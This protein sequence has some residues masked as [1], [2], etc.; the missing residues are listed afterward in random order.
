LLGR[1]GSVDDFRTQQF[2]IT[3]EIGERWEV[4]VDH[5]IL[6]LVE[7]DEPGR[8]D[9][10]SASLGYRLFDTS[11]DR[12]INRLTTGLGLRGYGDFGGE[13]IQNG[14][15]QL[16]RSSPEIGCSKG[17]SIRKN[18]VTDTGCE[19]VPC[20]QVTASWMPHWALTS[21]PGA[22]RSICGSG[23]GTTGAPGMRNQ[24]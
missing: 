3:G 17:K 20:G 11:D 15:H 22:A 23:C 9:Q 4:T 7:A 10:L 2:I 18:G 6:T 19:A 8:T 24:Y 21:R 1:G 13:R 14:S 12:A 5:S 16:V